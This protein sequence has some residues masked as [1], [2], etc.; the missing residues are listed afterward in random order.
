[1]SPETGK[2]VCLGGRDCDIAPSVPDLQQHQATV[3]D[4][5]RRPVDGRE[6]Q[7]ARVGSVRLRGRWKQPHEPGDQWEADPGERGGGDPDRERVGATTPRCCGGGAKP[8]PRATP[9]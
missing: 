7:E 8:R 3:D 9:V 4:G 6:L 2:S 5:R 1:V